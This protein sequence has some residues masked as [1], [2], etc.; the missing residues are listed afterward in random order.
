MGFKLI[1]GAGNEKY[2]KNC[3]LLDKKCYSEEYQGNLDTYMHIYRT[4]P[5]SFI[6]IVEG[7]TLIGYSIITPISDVAHLKMLQ[8][9][10]IDT[11]SLKYSDFVHYKK[12]SKL[13]V[14]SL[15]IHHSK[16]NNGLSNI[17]F[18]LCIKQSEEWR[19][20]NKKID[21][22]FADVINNKVKKIA[23]KR[24]FRFLKKTNH[25]SEIIGKNVGNKLVI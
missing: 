13:Y 3:I 25:N 16:R 1:Q 11:K 24:G 5:N 23:T 4:N 12:A 19:D 21:L 14:Y 22:L 20:K 7:E 6:F 10:C 17:L 18:D 2:I 9:D 8:G 15:V